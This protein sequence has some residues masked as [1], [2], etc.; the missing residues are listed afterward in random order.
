MSIRI[1]RFLTYNISIRLLGDLQYSIRSRRSKTE[2][3]CIDILMCAL[4]VHRSSIPAVDA[5]MQWWCN[6]WYSTQKVRCGWCFGFTW[7]AFFK[8]RSELLAGVHPCE[9]RI[10]RFMPLICLKG[11][12]KCVE[13]GNNS[14]IARVLSE[15]L[16]KMGG[17]FNACL[18]SDIV[19]TP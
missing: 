13:N 6:G 2:G 10:S 3:L 8:A 5:Y 15:C 14:R 19:R 18:F 17:F 16:E 4:R 11:V 7:W 12:S 9:P 1:L